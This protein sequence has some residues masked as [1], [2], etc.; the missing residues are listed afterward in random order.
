MHIH[1][2]TVALLHSSMLSIWL[3]F[4]KFKIQIKLVLRALE[5]G[6]ATFFFC[7][8]LSMLDLIVK[9]SFCNRKV[10]GECYGSYF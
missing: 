4:T 2:G 10:A 5:M 1:N 3:S 9:R 7:F 6:V 8:R